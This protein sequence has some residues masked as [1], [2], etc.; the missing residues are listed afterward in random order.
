MRTTVTID[1]DLLAQAKAQAAVSGKTL[2]TIVEDA[3]RVM[4]AS[5]GRDEQQQVIELPTF[6]GSL[7]PGVDLDDSAALHDLMDGNET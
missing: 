3:L 5:R 2:N 1:D 7:R 6:A 4:L